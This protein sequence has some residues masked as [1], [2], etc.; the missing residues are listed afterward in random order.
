MTIVHTWAHGSRRLLGS[1]HRTSSTS[2]AMSSPARH[3]GKYPLA[4]RN[5]PWIAVT[6]MSPQAC[7]IACRRGMR[8]CGW[9][10]YTRH[11]QAEK[12]SSIG[13]KNGEV[14]GQVY[15]FKLIVV[16]ESGLDQSSPMENWHYP[17]S[18]QTWADLVCSVQLYYGEHLEMW[19]YVGYCMDLVLHDDAE[20]LEGL[21]RHTM[22][23]F[24]RAALG[25]A[26]L[27]F[28]QL[29]YDP[30]VLF[31]SGR[32]QLHQWKWIHE[33][34]QLHPWPRFSVKKKKENILLYYSAT[35]TE[36]SPHHTG[37]CVALRMDPCGTD[38][39]HIQLLLD[40]TNTVL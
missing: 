27:P 37:T 16:G 23:Y 34:V 33:A 7:S 2:Q 6:W 11:L 35:H 30:V 38:M 19:V 9:R 29:H 10:S 17:I 40:F 20:A 4:C 26:Q 21:W 31:C 39:V 14:R 8:A 36:P 1:G 24:P 12:N 13:F 18:P 3:R 32:I 25:R 5:H 28:G 22:W 15:H